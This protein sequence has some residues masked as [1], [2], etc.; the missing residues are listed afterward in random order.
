MEKSKVYFTSFKTSFTENLMQ[1]LARL[2]KTAG[3]EN[4]DFQDHMQQSKFILENME[5]WHFC[6]RIMQKSLQIS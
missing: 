5:I 3:I 4:I 6:A 2:V 1:K